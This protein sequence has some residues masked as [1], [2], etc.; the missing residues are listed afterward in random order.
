MGIERE[1]TDHETESESGNNRDG[2]GNSRELKLPELTHKD[3][4][5]RVGSILTNDLKN[6]R[7]GD[8]PSLHRL[9][10]HDTLELLKVP[11]R[12]IVS[13]AA[14]VAQKW[15]RLHLRRNRGLI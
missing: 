5:N 1:N 13:S 15:R 10:P 12:S 9:T 7:T 3:I 6:D 2:N 11:R 4:G 8:G 14:A